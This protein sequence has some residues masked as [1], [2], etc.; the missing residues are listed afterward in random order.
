M[1]DGDTER[2]SGRD[3]DRD[4]EP[5]AEAESSALATVRAYYETLRDGEPL[6]SYFVADPKSAKFGITERLTG[7]EEI[8]EGLRTQTE[9]TTDW[10]VESHALV[11]GE[12]ENYAWFADRV[13]MAWTDTTT[14]ER[15][16]YET[17]WSGTLEDRAG[18]HEYDPGARS[19]AEDREGE[20]GN[21]GD[22]SNDEEGRAG[23]QFVSMH[24][25]RSES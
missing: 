18:D 7:Y 14:G 22:T 11:V 2:T 16:A 1:N 20:S 15:H 23:W 6:A 19:D 3:R 25:S 4:Q 13:S 12:R 17:R 9:T 24:V 8:A 21:A 10:T 5:E